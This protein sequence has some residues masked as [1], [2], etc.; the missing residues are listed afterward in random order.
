M[1]F[2]AYQVTITYGFSLKRGIDQDRRSHSPF[3][4]GAGPIL[5]WGFLSLD[6]TR[7]VIHEACEGYARR[8]VG[9]GRDRFIV[10][11]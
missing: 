1:L 11:Y 3:Y 5:R 6:G 4:A 10:R 2:L 7:V 8:L 9:L